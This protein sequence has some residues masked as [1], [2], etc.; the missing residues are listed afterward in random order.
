MCQAT[1]VA[2]G[3]DAQT[4]RL[5]SRVDGNKRCDGINLQQHPQLQNQTKM[6]KFNLMP[7]LKQQP[8]ERNIEIHIETPDDL[9]PMVRN[10]HE[11]GVH[12]DFSF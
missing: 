8:G 3:Q 11:T 7:L 6:R 10:T 12:H 5:G 9:R 1:G 2:F 4:W